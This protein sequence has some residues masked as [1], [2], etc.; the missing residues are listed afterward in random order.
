M[1]NKFLPALI[2][3][4][5]SPLAFGGGWEGFLRLGTL[6]GGSVEPNHL[7]W[8]EV[9][10]ATLAQINNGGGRS[11]NGLLGFQK[12][13]DQS[14]P[15]LALACA[16]GTV[17]SSGTLDLANTNASATVFLRLNLTNVIVKSISSSGTVTA[18]TDPVEQLSLQSQILCWNYTQFNPA[19]GL[20]QTYVKSTWDFDA[21]TG[22]YSNTTPLFMTTGIRKSTGVELDWN[23]AAGNRYRIYAVSDLTQPF[24]PIAEVTNVPGSASYTITPAAPAMFYIVE[25]LPAGD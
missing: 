21:N 2:C 25:Q 11:T 6:S 7:G 8:M 19:A 22:S 24:L 10:A 13:L 23:A 15:A 18:T 1:K 20:A 14:S 3:Y 4:W 5:L 9:Q 12:L 17:I 16:R